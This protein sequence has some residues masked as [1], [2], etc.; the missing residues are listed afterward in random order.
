[1][2]VRADVGVSQ[3]PGVRRSYSEPSSSRYRPRSHWVGALP[4]WLIGASARWL[5]SASATTAGFKYAKA[6][7]VLTE[8]RPAD[9]VVQGELDLFSEDADEEATPAEGSRAKLM[10]A[11]DALNLRF[12][13]DSVRLGS[14]AA[15]SSGA[16]LRAWATKQERRSPRYT[17]RW[18]EMPVVRAH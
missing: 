10:S 7:A 6:G 4:R 12:G 2:S 11:M 15:A 9:Q 14:T 5:S 13:R 8:L 16:E 17:T 1:M 18:N 3:F